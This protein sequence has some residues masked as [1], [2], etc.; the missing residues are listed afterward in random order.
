MEEILAKREDRGTDEFYTLMNT[1][2][3]KGPGDERHRSPT[4]RLITLK[5]STFENK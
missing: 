3:G 1:L 5:N 2:Y 4:K